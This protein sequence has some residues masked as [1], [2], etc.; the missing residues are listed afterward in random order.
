MCIKTLIAT[1]LAVS[2]LMLWLSMPATAAG[3]GTAGGNVC[4]AANTNDS[5]AVVGTCR[6][7]EGDVGAVYW[8]PGN[9]IPVALPTLEPDGPCGV[10]DINN[11]NVATG[12]CEEGAAG[13]FFP[14]RWTLS[15]PGSLSQRLNPLLGHVKAAARIINHASVVGG[16]SFDGSGGPSPVIW[17]AGQTSAI[18]L[19]EL[20]L[21]PPLLSSSA[22]CHIADMTDDANPVVVG[23]CSLDEGGSIAVRWQPGVLGYTVSRLPRLSG[24]SNCD[25]A[26]I[27][28]SGQIAGTCETED[29]D[30]VAVRWAA[31]NTVTYLDDLTASGPL[32]EQLAVADMNE[33]GIIVGNYLTDEGYSRAFLWAPVDDPANEEALDLGGLG[34]FWTAVTDIADNGTFTGAAQTNDGRAEGFMGSVA[35]PEIVSIGTLGGFTSAPAAL[36]DSGNHLA[37]TSQTVAGFN[38]AFLLSGTL[39][40]LTDASVSHTQPGLAWIQFLE[41][42]PLARNQLNAG[43]QSF[44][45]EGDIILTE[46]QI[47]ALLEM[48]ERKLSEEGH[49]YLKKSPFW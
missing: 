36:S 1:A 10:Y 21:L 38:N 13:E 18:E 27:N 45:A 3:L 22:G 43:V 15:L 28:Q 37:G 12:N 35:A 40:R 8:A 11:A 19:P 6:D 24:G 9:E 41:T 25:A 4:S 5:G 17:R 30:M 48:E 47:T 49:G 31:N 14:V 42:T 32:H 29:G 39:T 20:G 34:G 2:A 44:L 23:T 16:V 46:D 7:A 33:A 26:A